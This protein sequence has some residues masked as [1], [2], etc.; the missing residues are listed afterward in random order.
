MNGAFCFDWCRERVL[1]PPLT[2]PTRVDGGRLRASVLRLG[3]ALPYLCS[4]FTCSDS[5]TGPSC[6]RRAS[7]RTAM[8]PMGDYVYFTFLI[9]LRGPKLPNWCSILGKLC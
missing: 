1:V 9:T 2:Q 7:S 8:S 4:A 5:L 3:G 6:D